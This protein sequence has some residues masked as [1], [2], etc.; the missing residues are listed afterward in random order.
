MTDRVWKLNGDIL[1]NEW[2]R[3]YGLSE[4]ASRREPY[5]LND[6]VDGRDENL[7]A[8]LAELSAD[9]RL[10]FALF[11]HARKFK[12]RG[13]NDS[14]VAIVTAPYLARTVDVFGGAGEANTLA[15][16]IAR[17]LGLNVRVG[18]PADTIYLSNRA[19]DPTLPIVWWQPS[20]VSLP[21]PEV[22]DPNPRYESRME[23]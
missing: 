12:T 15:H 13:G 10:R 3:R 5:E 14:I 23:M 8:T 1:P 20:R 4:R 17:S 9:Q 11:D 22:E 6:L 7:R 21:F 2:G 16:G 18:H 19:D